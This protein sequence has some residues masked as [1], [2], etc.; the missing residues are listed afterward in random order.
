MP[1]TARGSS[2]ACP[3]PTAASS[4]RPRSRGRPARPGHLPGPAVALRRS[5]MERPRLRVRARPS[6]RLHPDLDRLVELMDALSAIKVPDDPGPF[7]RAADRWKAYV[8]DP[9]TA[10]VFAGPG[11]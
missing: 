6:R 7:K 9:E 3:Q 1:A 2:R 11:L 8:D 10:A 4:P 5:R